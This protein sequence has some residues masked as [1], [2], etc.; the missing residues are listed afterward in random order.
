MK[1]KIIRLTKSKSCRFL[2]LYEA[3]G[4]YLRFAIYSDS[5]MW[6][7]RD[8]YINFII[9]SETLVHKNTYF[10]NGVV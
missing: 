4:T 7:S 5:L 3:K 9:I 10:M 8:I 1:N 2:I 6:T